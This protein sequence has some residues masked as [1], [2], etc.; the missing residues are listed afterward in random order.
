MFQNVLLRLQRRPRLSND[1]LEVFPFPAVFNSCIFPV[2]VSFLFRICSTLIFT[3]QP[4][5]FDDFAFSSSF[6]LLE[7]WSNILAGL[8][9]SLY[10]LQDEVLISAQSKCFAA[11]T[12]TRAYLGHEFSECSK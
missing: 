12:R 2:L 8:H 6:T 3:I 11:K 9:F 10:L 5:K 4:G 1:E 7:E